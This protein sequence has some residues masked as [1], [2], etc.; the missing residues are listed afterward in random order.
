MKLTKEDLKYPQIDAAF[1][2]IYDNPN[3]YQFLSRKSRGDCP[4]VDC[5]EFGIYNG[6]SLRKITDYLSCN[7]LTG[8]TGYVHAFDSFEGLPK[9]EADIP[10]F[11]KFHKG[12]YK[13]QLTPRQI[14]D[15]IPYPFTHIHKCWFDELNNSHKGYK[16]LLI[17]I[18]C[19]LYI[20]T[21][22]ALQFML[23]RDLVGV[24]TLIAYDEYESTDNPE[25][26]G[27]RRAHEEIFNKDCEWKTDEIWHNIY[28]DKDNGQRIRQSVFEVIK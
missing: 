23:G 10:V 9:E 25:S 4:I 12:A 8:Y 20:S 2:Y 21:K 1:R 11:D 24:N 17:H 19:D 3:K 14:K 16:A 28:Y 13:T 5:Y 7:I 6:S 18:D 26:S 15:S 22:H 27:E